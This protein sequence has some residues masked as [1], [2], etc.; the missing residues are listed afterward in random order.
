MF[1]TVC[2]VVSVLRPNCFH[3]NMMSPEPVVL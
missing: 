2:F 3:F 1:K